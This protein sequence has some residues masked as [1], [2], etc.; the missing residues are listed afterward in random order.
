M[1]QLSQVVG[2]ITTHV[3]PSLYH[4]GAECYVAASLGRSFVI[5]NT[6]S[7]SPFIFSPELPGTISAIIGYEETTLV[8]YE[9]ST[10]LQFFVRGT[11]VSELSDLPAPPRFL[12]MGRYVLAYTT[13]GDYTVY[14]LASR[15]ALYPV[16]RFDTSAEG[17][18]IVGMCHPDGYVNKVVLSTSSGRLELHNFDK[19]RR[20]YVFGSSS[21]EMS[22]EGKGLFCLGTIAASPEVDVVAFLGLL[23]G[24]AERAARSRATHAPLSMAEALHGG[25]R[26]SLMEE[27]TQASVIIFHLKTGRVLR[28]FSA[29]SLRPSDYFTSLCFSRADQ[30]CYAGTARGDLFALS[31]SKGSVACSFPAAHGGLITGISFIPDTYLFTAGADNAIHIYNHDTRLQVLQH[32]KHRSGHNGPISFAQF[33]A[34]NSDS[35]VESAEANPFLLTCGQVDKAMRYTQIYKRNCSEVFIPLEHHRKQAQSLSV[36]AGAAPGA[37][38]TRSGKACV[39]VSAN[40]IRDAHWANVV[41]FNAGESFCHVWSFQR[42]S[43]LLEPMEDKFLGRAAQQR[44]E[45]K[46]LM[47]DNGG[48]LP[49]HM[50]DAILAQR[51]QD[52]YRLALPST[53]VFL[54]NTAA[55]YS[56]KKA[57][58]QF[59]RGDGSLNLAMLSAASVQHEDVTWAEISM[60]GG[61]CAMGGSG[62]SLAVYAMQSGRLVGY[63]LYSASGAAGEVGDDENPY[64]VLCFFVAGS[65]SIFVVRADGRIEQRGLDRQLTVWRKWSHVS[66]HAGASEASPRVVH[67]IQAVHHFSSILAVAT[68]EHVYIYSLEVGDVVSTGS[69]LFSSRKTLYGCRFSRELELRSPPM[70]HC[71]SF[72]NDGRRLLLAQESDLWVYDLRL[73]SVIHSQRMPA[74]IASVSV[75]TDSATVAIVYVGMDGAY[76]YKNRESM[77]LP[78]S[79]ILEAQKALHAGN[80]EAPG[81]DN[82]TG[83]ESGRNGGASSDPAELITTDRL[84]ADRLLDL[85][86]NRQQSKEGLAQFGGKLRRAKDPSRVPLWMELKGVSGR[87]TTDPTAGQ[88]KAS[89]DARQ[90]AP[91]SAQPLDLDVSICSP[92]FSKALRSGAEACARILASHPAAALDLDISG[93]RGEDIPLWLSRLDALLSGV[94]GAARLPKGASFDVISSVFAL[95]LRCH[96]ARLV[97]YP[98]AGETISRLSARIAREYRRVREMAEIVYGFSEELR[99]AQTW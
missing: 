82:S 88:D 14:D 10:T 57:A 79:S 72:F 76:L 52:K 54:E 37:T 74:E 45:L 20:L 50:Q 36:G 16:R 24:A 92:V 51:W 48:L 75:S 98:Q 22:S 21:K 80:P 58:R 47:K 3:P 27:V 25:G 89:H 5:Y 73:A 63:D 9:S 64:V 86:K 99:E 44:K 15:E 18:R 4:L 59:E 31:L 62:G 34:T 53:A 39:Q 69:G 83:A 30:Y 94:V 91:G 46:K 84:K 38:V 43:E 68:A 1:F 28:S 11:L 42:N 95:T 19:N 65:D 87:P 2:T 56:E 32:V 77:G 93:L 23:G 41:T 60:C 7:L 97:K 13:S 29:A 96:Q 78:I 71:M 61:F 90:K 67:V 35:I 49:E 55:K 8:A 17:E 26:Q 12:E 70:P 6:D 81:P 40:P 33:Y 85:V 66:L